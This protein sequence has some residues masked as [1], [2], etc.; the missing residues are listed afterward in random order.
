[1]RKIKFRGWDAIGEKGWVFGDLVHNQRVTATGL[2][3]AIGNIYRN[4]E[5]LNM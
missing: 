1:M 4:P 2:V 3:R 5:L